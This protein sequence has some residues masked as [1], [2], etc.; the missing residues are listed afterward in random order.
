MTPD[1]FDSLMFDSLSFGDGGKRVLF[2]RPT[3]DERTYHRNPL[4]DPDLG[5]G[6]HTFSLDELHCLHLGVLQ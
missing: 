2:W 5:I 6:L 3:P 1:M 4:L